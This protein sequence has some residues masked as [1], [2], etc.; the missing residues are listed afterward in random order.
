MPGHAQRADFWQII[1]LNCPHLGEIHAS[2]HAKGW[3]PRH[4]QDCPYLLVTCYLTNNHHGA[5]Q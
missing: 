3:H 1:R 2:P 4:I 5:Q